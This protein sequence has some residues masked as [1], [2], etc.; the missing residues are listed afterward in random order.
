MEMKTPAGRV[1]VNKRERMVKKEMQSMWRVKM[2][3]RV[4]VKVIW[5]M[6]TGKAMVIVSFPAPAPAPV[7]AVQNQSSSGQRDHFREVE[8]K[9]IVT[10]KKKLFL[11][12]CQAPLT[13]FLVAF[14]LAVHVA[15]F[16]VFAAFAVPEDETSFQKPRLRTVGRSE[17]TDEAHSW[18]MYW[19]GTKGN[20]PSRTG[21]GIAD[22]DR[23][24]I[25]IDL[26]IVWNQRVEK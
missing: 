7:L 15:L 16:V 24:G 18:S 13:Y 4:K 26:D 5:L 12:A 11:F 9:E 25:D 8:S 23:V 1:K 22:A 20:H 19:A 6:L 10:G 21:I 14:A 2:A 17:N 3:E